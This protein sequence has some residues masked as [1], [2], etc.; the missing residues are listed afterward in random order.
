MERLDIRFVTAL[1]YKNYL[2]LW[3]NQLHLSC[4]FDT[5]CPRCA[6]HRKMSAN[7]IVYRVDISR[8][9]HLLQV[10]V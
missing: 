10:K 2:E 4:W 1:V 3:K 5:C 6:D 8:T 9:L 7:L